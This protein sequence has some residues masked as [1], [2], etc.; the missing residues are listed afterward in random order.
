MLAQRLQD[1]LDAEQ[2]QSAE[3]STTSVST[4][5]SAA[6][7]ATESSSE[8]SAQTA[9]A[10]DE[11]VALTPTEIRKRRAAHF[12]I[13]YQPTAAE[14]KRLRQEKFGTGAAEPASTAVAA[15]SGAKGRGKRQPISEEQIEALRERALKFGGELPDVVRRFDEK[16]KQIERQ[17]RFTSVSASS[18]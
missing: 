10:T 6:P 3:A 17:Q 13:E 9:A 16:K 11:A 8:P 15:A 2:E 1:A 18:K 5:T 14:L 4:E 12:G 7:V